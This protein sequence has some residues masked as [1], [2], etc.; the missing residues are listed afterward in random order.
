VPHR[1]FDQRLQQQW[2]HQHAAV[3]FVAFDCEPQAILKTNLLDLE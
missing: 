1:V 2:W 3:A